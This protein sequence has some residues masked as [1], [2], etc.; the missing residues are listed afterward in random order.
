MA[1]EG[2]G[3][4]RVTVYCEFS[5]DKRRSDVCVLRY[6]EKVFVT[7]VAMY[8]WSTGEQPQL[9]PV[10]SKYANAGHADL[11]LIS[12]LQRLLDMRDNGVVVPG[13]VIALIVTEIAETYADGR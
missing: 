10:H 9:E 11:K 12:V 3:R 2:D 13:D 6:G 1:V 5:N 7:H 8:G 4:G